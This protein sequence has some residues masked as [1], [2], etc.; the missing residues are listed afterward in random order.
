MRRLAATLLS[1]LL[2]L[3]LYASPTVVPQTRERTVTPPKTDKVDTVKVDVDLVVLDALVLQKKTA[4][5][6][7]DLK[8]SDFTLTE[9]GVKQEITHFSQDASPLSVL[10][11]VDRG[12]CLDPFGREVRA[13]TRD[14]LSRLRP[15]DE[16]ALMAYSDTVELVQGFVRD[17]RRVEEALDRVP[18][19]NEE[20]QHCLNRALF[21]AA[22]YMMEAGN[23]VGRRV[24]IFITAV[25][26]NTDCTDGPSGKAATRAVYESGSVVCGLIPSSTAQRIEDG[27]ARMGTS[28]GKIFKVPS[29]SIKELAEETGGEVL[30]DKPEILDRTFNTLIE[31]LR[32]RY[33]LGFVS[34]NKKRDGTT[35]KL[36]LEINPALKKS[37]G[38]LVVK[39]RRTYIAPKS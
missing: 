28:I 9:D 35:R 12:G 32:T 26:S 7:G 27:A 18:Q 31:H 21:D 39:T 36:K 30:D 4:R 3:S 20:A 22:L 23:P 19:S 6:V 34:T 38:E 17:R 1:T 37:Q 15:Q 16:V 5:V 14:A 8:Q 11:M 13:A 2:I 24:I 33:Q 10:L 25:T 29:L